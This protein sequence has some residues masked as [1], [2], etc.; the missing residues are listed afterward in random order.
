MCLIALVEEIRMIKRKRTVIK[1][2]KQGSWSPR[3][4]ILMH[5]A[6]RKMLRRSSTFFLIQTAE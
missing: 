5:N 1:Q 3:R 2:R 6:H 4:K